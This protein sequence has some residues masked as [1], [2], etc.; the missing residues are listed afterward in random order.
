[1]Q[2]LCRGLYLL[3]GLTLGVVLPDFVFGHDWHRAVSVPLRSLHPCELAGLLKDRPEIGSVDVLDGKPSLLPSTQWLVD[4]TL[5]FES[6][7][8]SLLVLDKALDACEA[9]LFD[10]W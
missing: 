10:V 4:A 5:R 9:L 2:G 8:R 3:L 6:P 7:D 1:M